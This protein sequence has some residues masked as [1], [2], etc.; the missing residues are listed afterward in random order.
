MLTH[1]EGLNPTRISFVGHSLGNIIV[2][3]ALSKPQ[4]RP[5]LPRLHT[6]L[7]LSGPHLG[8]LY[9]SSGLINMGKCNSTRFSMKPKLICIHFH[10]SLSFPISFFLFSFLY[11]AGLWFMQK[12]KKVGS[13]QQLCM[14]D[15][16]DLRKCF[17]YKLSQRSN[18]H[19]F[20]NIVSDLLF[21]FCF[22]YIFLIHYYTNLS[23]CVDRAKTA[24]CRLI[25]LEWS[26]A[27]E[28]FVIIPY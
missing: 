24:T 18:L 27:R 6:F 28:L 10:P 2:R 17:L 22:R 4:M 8:T 5:I 12:I 1:M 16:P 23:Y 25:L 3:S 26:C 19:F 9:N 21:L 7:S 14:R 11:L 13:L 20:K 15:K